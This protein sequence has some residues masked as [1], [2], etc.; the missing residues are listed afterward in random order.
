MDALEGFT[1]IIN[2]FVAIVII[3][4]VIERKKD[5]KISN[6]KLFEDSTKAGEGDDAKLWQ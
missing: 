2:I 4:D 5:Q 6:M 1:I 3:V